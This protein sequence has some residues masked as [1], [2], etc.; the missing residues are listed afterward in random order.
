MRWVDDLVASLKQLG[1][2]ADLGEIYRS[3]RSRRLDGKRSLPRTYEATI[4]RTLED[5]SSDSA[6]H[7]AADLFKLIERGRWGLR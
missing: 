2:E 6:N 7:R 4:R 1:G 5:H 3:V